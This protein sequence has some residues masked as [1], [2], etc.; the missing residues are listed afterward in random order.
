[1][2]R[3]VTQTKINMKNILKFCSLLNIVAK[4]ELAGG[5]SEV[6]YR[7]H[8][9]HALLAFWA[10]GRIRTAF[11]NMV[12]HPIIFGLLIWMFQVA[13][14]PLPNLNY[15]SPG[16]DDLPWFMNMPQNMRLSGW[17]IGVF[18][19]YLF[20]ESVRDMFSLAR[21]NR[22]WIHVYEMVCACD[23][24][25]SF[26]LASRLLGDWYGK[27]NGKT[28]PRLVCSRSLSGVK[29]TRIPLVPTAPRD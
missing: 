15:F 4:M 9:G 10:K 18:F 16:W 20:V 17:M 28:I 22:L 1:V 24:R 5:Y 3:Q 29:P 14:K 12:V 26:E 13:I 21:N 8:G 25:G 27:V 2:D 6:S 11:M 7:Q 19:G 23:N